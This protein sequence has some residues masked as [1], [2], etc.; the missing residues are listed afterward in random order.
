MLFCLRAGLKTFDIAFL[1]LYNKRRT[2]LNG[3]FGMVIGILKLKQEVGA[4]ANFRFEYAASDSLL[5]LPDA[6]F[7]GNVV[8]DGVATAKGKDLFV[9]MTVSYAVKCPCSRCLE[10]ARAEVEIPFSTKFTLFPK[11]DAYLYKSG[12]ADLTPAADE[13]IL[14][15]QPSVVYCKPDCKGLCHICGAN[16]NNGDCGHGNNY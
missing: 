3:V 11:E 12:R 2:T 14:L 1:I 6:K 9:D 10:P 16:L 13:A 4:T 15:S 5:A 7:D 8:L